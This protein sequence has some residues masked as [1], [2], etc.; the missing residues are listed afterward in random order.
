MGSSS[1]TGGSVSTSASS[2]PA[3]SAST[4]STAT[5]SMTIEVVAV[6]VDDGSGAMA[7]PAGGPPDAGNTAPRDHGITPCWSHISG[8]CGCGG[9]SSS[10][11]GGGDG[12]GSGAGASGLAPTDAGPD[13]ATECIIC[14]NDM[15]EG[16]GQALKTLSCGHKFHEPCV[17][18]WLEKDG[19]CPICRRQIRAPTRPPHQNRLDAEAAVVFEGPGGFGGMRALAS[20]ALL[21]LESRRLMMLSTVEAALAVLMMSYVVDAISPAFMILSAGVTF[22]GASN[23]VAKA[24]SAARPCLV[25]SAAYHM[26]MM[27]RVVHGQSGSPFFSETW[28]SARMVLFSLFCISFMELAMLKKAFHLHHHLVRTPQIELRALRIHRRS[29]TGWAQRTIIL[30]M[31]ALICA[32][33]IARYMCRTEAAGDRERANQC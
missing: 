23:Y 18:E 3:S 19:R 25:G 16:D 26:Y 6:A 11:G 9:S 31:F 28:G 4:T 7:P 15:C 2:A 32:P 33:V 20:S 8:G 24:V 13:E 29:Q 14:L 10:S 17:E 27:A 22:F 30:V 21:V 5:A 1:S 12:D